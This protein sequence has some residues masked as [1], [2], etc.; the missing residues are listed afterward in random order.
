MQPFSQCRKDQA[1]DADFP[2]RDRGDKR[3]TIGYLVILPAI[4]TIL[5][6]S[7]LLDFVQIHP[8][9]GTYLTLSDHVISRLS[10]LATY[11]FIFFLL[12]WP[13]ILAV[14]N[15]SDRAEIALGV[16]R[17]GL[18]VYIVILHMP[19]FLIL[20]LIDINWNSSPAP[21]WYWLIVVLIGALF[22]AA[23]F[24]N[25]HHGI[26]EF[27][28]VREGN[29][30]DFSHTPML[31][32]VTT[33]AG[34][35]IFL[36]VFFIVELYYV[37]K[38]HVPNSEEM[39][40][41]FFILGRKS[42][43]WKYFWISFFLALFPATVAFLTAVV[44]NRL[45][46]S[47]L[48]SAT[49]KQR[50]VCGLLGKSY[51]YFSHF[52]RSLI[53]KTPMLPYL[54]LLSMV[55]FL[56]I[57]FFAFSGRP[58][59]LAYVL[60]PDFFVLFL[61]ISSVW[62]V[63]MIFALVH[64]DE[65]FGTYFFL[66]LEQ[67]LIRIQKHKIYMGYGDLGQRAVNRELADE[68]RKDAR[69]K[70]DRRLFRRKSQRLFFQDI[71]T[72]DVQLEKMALRV[73]I[74]E[75]DRSKIA[76]SSTS[77]LQGEYGVVEALQK[78]IVTQ[79][80]KGNKIKTFTRVLVPMIVGDAAE[81]F[82]MSRAN[83][84]RADQIISTVADAEKVQTIYR[85]AYETDTPAIIV[86][87]RSDQIAYY[88]YQTR[89]K[90]I[91]TIYPEHARGITLGFHLLAMVR[92]LSAI[93]SKPKVLPKILFVGNNKSNQYILETLWAHLLLDEKERHG[94]FE[95]NLAYLVIDEKQQYMYPRLKD[96]E[97][98]VKIHDPDFDKFTPSSFISGARYPDISPSKS[99]L[100]YKIPL[101]IINGRDIAVVEQILEKYSPDIIVL[102]HSNSEHQPWILARIVRALERIKNR[103]EDEYSLPMMMLTSSSG[104]TVETVTLGDAMKF[105]NAMCMLNNDMPADSGY[106]VHSF[107][108]RF[109][110]EL[111]GE[112]ISDLLSDPEEVIVGAS[113]CFERM[114]EHKKTDHDKS[115]LCQYVEINAC[116]PNKPGGLAELL[117]RLAGV[118]FRADPSRLQQGSANGM[119]GN[120]RDG[121]DTRKKYYSGEAIEKI[122][123]SGNN[124]V[125]YTR[126][127]A[128]HLPTFQYLQNMTLNYEQNG[129]IISGYASLTRFTPEQYDELIAT[130]DK[131][132]APVVKRIYTTDGNKYVDEKFDNT[133]AV[134]WAFSQ[135]Y[136]E[137][138]KRD[139]REPSPAVVP[140]ILDR[141][142]W[143][144]DKKKNTTSDFYQSLYGKEKSEKT[145]EETKQK[146]CPGMNGCR[147]AAYQDWV[148]ASNDI[149]L[150]DYVKNGKDEELM[151]AR[152][153]RCCPDIS[154][155]DENLLPKADAHFARVFCC[156][157]GEYQPGLLAMIFNAFVFRL[158]HTDLG[159]SDKAIN[160][161][162]L[163]DMNCKNTYYSMSRIFG[164]VV[165]TTETGSESK[166]IPYPVHMIR[167]LPYGDP[168]SRK[169][170]FA[171]AR[172]LWQFLN[173][174]H[175]EI[176]VNKTFR[177]Y[178]T[179]Q[180]RR[181]H[182][183]AKEYDQSSA[184]QH[185][186]AFPGGEGESIPDVIVIKRFDEE[187]AIYHYTD[188][189]AEGNGS[190]EQGADAQNENT[191]QKPQ[192]RDPGK[193]LLC[194]I[195]PREHDCS[196]FRVW[197]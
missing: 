53:L 3:K 109:S 41:D 97:Q 149:R 175:K 177:F 163:A 77:Q 44:P 156:C 153:Y 36:G 146:A 50:D 179:D 9:F 4:L 98:V 180:S 52:F 141:T 32:K 113:S 108:N 28:K 184:D 190:G 66:V 51:R 56:L 133:Q 140:E 144:K 19:H 99:D 138:Y 29:K 70:K 65:T 126:D 168:E 110:K 18:L 195:Q 1:P 6:S 191:A 94:F 128:M 120:G 26:S 167:I 13:Q 164:N 182:Y 132:L 93:S 8:Y 21:F 62:F 130:A 33:I 111:V 92:K 160:I 193:C 197:I 135:N 159:G 45:M 174:Y 129:I 169:H 103:E 121:D 147:I 22:V 23:G 78:Q 71:V 172:A 79:D 68:L 116:Y 158:E 7:M 11:L 136:F 143:D 194:G 96:E 170:W 145:T 12:W 38:H 102:F 15:F 54:F 131:S 24:Y 187:R 48:M 83:I 152:N 151:H 155:A 189:P 10:H 161:S 101:R 88:T 112:S 117:A 173:D 171:Y 49:F 100:N 59:E 107:F 34:T 64:P 176:G 80:A 37:A 154:E 14:T 27:R 39:W 69:K 157:D 81:A 137:A 43:E 178:W 86:V 87:P 16:L 82:T 123:E 125:K 57:F 196:K 188:Q 60:Q 106:P 75:K 5:T 61:A 134:S 67:H 91:A 150:R 25:S 89:H 122:W 166:R 42:P 104:D 118:D 46:Y 119:E 181:K 183:F 127:I 35:I 90:K 192:Q 2:L 31:S 105:Y 76:F 40:R 74:V 165:N 139:Y 124:G 47:V 186:D 95:K 17:D 63:P 148:V 185:A 73:L 72:P 20:R 114:E 84:D 115:D 58:D 85:Y 30:P 162:Y 55:Y 142:T